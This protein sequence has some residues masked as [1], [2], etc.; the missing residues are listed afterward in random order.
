M[1]ER[2]LLTTDGELNQAALLISPRTLKLFEEERIE[3]CLGAANATRI[4]N[5]CDAGGTFFSM[6]TMIRSGTYTEVADAGIHSF[7]T[8]MLDPKIAPMTIP[9]GA[10]EQLIDVLAIGPHIFPASHAK[11]NV[12]SGWT[13]T[14]LKN[15]SFDVSD[16]DSE[17]L[18]FDQMILNL[19]GE[20]IGKDFSP[21]HEAKIRAALEPLTELAFLAGELK[22]SE[23]T[24]HDV[25]LGA[26]NEH[27]ATVPR[28]AA[29]PVMDER[30]DSEK[31]VVWLTA[32]GSIAR[33]A[34]A[35]AQLEVQAATKAR[36]EAEAADKKAKLAEQQRLLAL[37]HESVVP[38][39]YMLDDVCCVSCMLSWYACRE[40]KDQ[41]LRVQFTQCTT[42]A[43]WWCP[44]CRPKPFSRHEQRCETRARLV[45]A[46]QTETPKLKT[47][48][49]ARVPPKP[50]KQAKPK[51]PKQASKKAKK[52]SSQRGA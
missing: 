16:P 31:R 45:A 34:E 1:R 32:P 22:E 39:E 37:A 27:A 6:K 26:V 43:Q 2:I 9:K 15:P 30:T 11:K 25:P 29:R 13:K 47:K 14:G 42:C 41:G 19:G 4:Q 8:A 17:P 24:E 23:L 3:G 49:R 52:S 35:K 21:E 46:A 12:E 28:Q 44:A 7:L 18:V 10:R 5:P 50:S 38:S 33:R 36:A 48:K 20:S 40:H 51:K